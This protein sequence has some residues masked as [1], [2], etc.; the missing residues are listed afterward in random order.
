VDFTGRQDYKQRISNWRMVLEKYSELGSQQIDTLADTLA[1]KFRLSPGKIAETFLCSVNGSEVAS[2]QGAELSKTLH[3]YAGRLCTPKLGTLAERFK[4]IARWDSLVLP[5]R[6]SRLLRDITRQVRYR[7]K[8]L[9]EWCFAQ[10][11]NRGKGVAALFFGPSGTGKTMAVE[12]IANELE[13]EV[14]RIDLSSVVS[15]YIGETE[16]NLSK[17]FREAQDSDVVLF[18]DEADA[19]FG[20]RSEIKDAH[21][22]YANIETN[23]LLQQIENYDGIVILATNMRQNMDKAFIRRIHIAIGFELPGPEDR[24]R[25]WNKVLPQSAPQD[26]DIDFEFLAR[27]FELS[28]GH[29][30]NIGLAAAFLAAEEGAPISMRHLVVGVQ[31]ELHKSGRRWFKEDFGACAHYLD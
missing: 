12:V 6:Q 31:R 21:D 11:M 18:F 20:K 10:T 30:R 2:L 29:V 26:A 14:F 5:D 17:I 13:M 19:L 16:K 24:L 15:K 8:V 9:E 25:I 22:R 7:R 4:P 23:Y 3:Y 27:G 28:G 1:A